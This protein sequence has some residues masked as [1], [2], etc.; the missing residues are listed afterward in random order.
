MGGA[1]SCLTRE[2]NLRR[3][4][5]AHLDYSVTIRLSEEGDTPDH[6]NFYSNSALG[7]TPSAVSTDSETATPHDGQVGVSESDQRLRESQLSEPFPRDSVPLLENAP[8]VLRQDLP[9]EHLPKEGRVFPLG[10]AANDGR[11]LLPATVAADHI[12]Q[13]FKTTQRETGR[14]GHSSHYNKR[15]DRKRK[16]WPSAGRKSNTSERPFICQAGP[17]RPVNFNLAVGNPLQPK[18]KFRLGPTPALSDQP[19]CQEETAE[20]LSGPLSSPSLMFQLTARIKYIVHKLDRQ[21]HAP[22]S[23][24][25]GNKGGAGE[26]LECHLALLM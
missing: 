19:Q 6:V 16:G 5:P 14:S 11:S 15:L 1:L 9:S 10:D 22:L 3:R 13:C 18:L 8:E 26:Y 17:L 20:V 2:T 4:R 12:D 25:E 21:T 7:A 23:G 24:G